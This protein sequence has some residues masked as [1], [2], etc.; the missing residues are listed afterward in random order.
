MKTR[1]FVA[2]GLLGL[3]AVWVL[4]PRS[5]TTVEQRYQIPASD[6]VVYALADDRNV[7]PEAGIFAVRVAP[8]Q[9]QNH[10]ATI[11][12]RGRTQAFRHVNVRAETPGQVVATPFPR[13]ARVNTGDVLC[14]LAVDNR[15]VELQEA[16]SR[17]QQAR[18]EYEAELDLERR[19]LQARV[20]I[21]QRKATLDAATAAVAR[22]QLN[23]ERTRIRAPFSG[24]IE[25]RQ[26]EVGDYL[27]MGG[28]CASVLD[29]QP[30]L[31]I[32]QVAEHEVG[33]IS[34]GA[35]AEGRLIT[36]EIVSGRVTFI[37]RAA[38]PTTRSY[39]LEIELDPADKVIRQGVTAEI[40]VATGEV[41][42]HLIPPSS[43]TLD[44]EGTPGVKAVDNENRVQFH[45]VNIIGESLALDDSGGF[46][47]TG[48]P[49]S[50]N[51]IT[52]GQ[53]LVFPGQVV[54]SDTSWA[55][56]N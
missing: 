8:L 21:A 50:V 25:Q 44:D 9:Q 24:V 40:M 4:I 53:E 47:V 36:G 26:I 11:R 54:R 16:L 51:L 10:I 7:A 19:G 22:A 52:V 43:L 39:R 41:M 32:G 14:E 48:L 42:A 45:P 49:A 12:V 56:G 1:H 28:V 6:G 30:M 29:D 55:T 2:I 18:M 33:R 31:M 23:L 20:T 3:M 13:G 35:P 37:S 46:W 38:D 27:D 15:E 34:E 5:N 17:E